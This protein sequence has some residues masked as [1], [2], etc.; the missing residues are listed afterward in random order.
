M[1]AEVSLEM[2]HSRRYWTSLV[3]DFLHRWDSR[4]LPFRGIHVYTAYTDTVIVDKAPFS[5]TK[6]RGGNYSIKL[7]FQRQR[8]DEEVIR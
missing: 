7:H 8:H 4:G 5:A 6:T 2:G 3:A 1:V